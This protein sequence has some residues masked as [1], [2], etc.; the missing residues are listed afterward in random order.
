M[1][2][3]FS[4]F[5]F[6]GRTRFKIWTVKKFPTPLSFPTIFSHHA[7]LRTEPSFL[8]LYSL[9]PSQLLSFSFIFFL[10]VFLS[11]SLSDSLLIS[12][13]F[14][15]SDFLLISPSPSFFGFHT[16]SLSIF[17]SSSCHQFLSSIYTRACLDLGLSTLATRHFFLLIFCSCCKPLF[18]GHEF[19]VLST[20]FFFF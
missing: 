5:Y 14:S 9:V 11:Q 13:W 20:Q 17:K 12:P 6:Y 2:Q 10:L 16:N 18:V 7:Y 4:W 1:C 8:N 15:L 3:S 19:V